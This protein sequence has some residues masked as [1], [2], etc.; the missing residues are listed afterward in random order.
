MRHSIF[1]DKY[2]TKI[3]EKKEIVFYKI[4][5]DIIANPIKAIL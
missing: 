1:Y 2:F 3:L 5:I 4:L